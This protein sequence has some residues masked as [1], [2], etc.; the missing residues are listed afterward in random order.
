ML[1]A[2]TLANFIGVF[3]SNTLIFRAAGF[4]GQEFWTHR[5]LLD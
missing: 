1:A 5:P 4:P 3:G 2:N